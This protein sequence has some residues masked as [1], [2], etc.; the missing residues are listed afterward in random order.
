[1]KRSSDPLRA[2]CRLPRRRLPG[3]AGVRRL[4]PSARRQHH[5][6]NSDAPPRLDV[7]VPV[8]N[9]GANILP[10]LQSILRAVR[11]PL[12]VLICYDRDE[13]DTLPAINNN[14]AALG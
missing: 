3:P 9:E 7:I 11:T 14:R 13:D 1:R 6:M 8:Y 10:N 2:A 5:P 12:R 4:G